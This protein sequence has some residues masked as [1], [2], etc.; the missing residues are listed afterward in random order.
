MLFFRFDALRRSRR[1]EKSEKRKN[2]SLKK[3]SSLSLS[4]SRFS[5]SLFSLSR[6]SLALCFSPESPSSLFENENARSSS[7]RERAELE[8]SN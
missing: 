6:F 1:G 7:P 5:P 8:A 2:R 4:T 3:K